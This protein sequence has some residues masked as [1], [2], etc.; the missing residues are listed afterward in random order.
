MEQ[1]RYDRLVGGFL[2]ME[3]KGRQYID[4]IV[5]QLVET[6]KLLDISHLVYEARNQNSALGGMEKAP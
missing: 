2:A 5:R 3:T 4:S 1:E 6:A